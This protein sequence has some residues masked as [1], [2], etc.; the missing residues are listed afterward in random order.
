MKLSKRA[1]A[2]GAAVLA[3]MTLAACGGS[4][5]SSSSSSGGAGGSCPLGEPDESITTTVRIAYQKIPNG[6]LIVKDQQILEN[7]MP[8]ATIT[9]NVFASGGDV[10]QAYGAG[11]VDM[12][13]TGSNPAV[14]ALSA[15][16]DATLPPTVNTWIFDV[17]GDGESLIVK[18]EIKSAADLKGKQIATPFSSTAHY[19]LL[20]YL[21]LNGLSETDVTL[22]NLEPEKMVAAWPD[23]AGVFVWDPTMSEVIAQGGV[24]LASAKDSAAGGF[25]TYDLANAVKSFADAN[26]PYMNMW[27]KA[28]DYAVNMIINEPD[29]A[30]A[31]ISAELAVPP[32]EVVK[33]FAGYRYLTAAEQ[34][35]PEWLGGGLGESFFKTAEFLVT[36]GAIDAV[37]TPE[38]YAAGVTNQYAAEAA[39]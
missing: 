20:K 38:A 11:A 4:G 21:E 15:P 8:N 2:A 26:G 13:L 7:C 29:K 31:S 34:A 5:D 28:Q 27:A 24:R 17:I 32:E 3:V 14:K 6:D 9:W 30:A 22:V 23:L 35:S 10:I 25:A 16:L 39:K 19:S 36:Q 1:L 37:N 18:P 12:G 33:M